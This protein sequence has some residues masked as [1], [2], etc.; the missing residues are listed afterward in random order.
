MAIHPLVVKL[1]VERPAVLIHRTMLKIMKGG[2]RPLS[3]PCSPDII[4]IQ[5][6]NM[7]DNVYKDYTFIYVFQHD[8]SSMNNAKGQ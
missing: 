1:V 2:R 7:Y 8:N 6:K 3:W 5:S 4:H